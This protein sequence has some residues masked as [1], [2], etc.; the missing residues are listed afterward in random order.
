MNDRHNLDARILFGA[1]FYDEYRVTGSL[2]GDLDLMAAAGFS[3][4]RV[5]ESVWST[6]EPEPGRFNLDWLEPLLDA[7]ADRGI[8]V[9]LGTP[10]YAVPPWLQ[11]LHPEIA[12]EHRTGQP[13]PWGSRQEVNYRSTAFLHYAERVIRAVMGRY[14]QHP[15]IIGF[16]VDNEPGFHLLHNADVFEGFLDHL[17]EK[18]GTVD[19]LNAEW[20]LTYW[21]HLLR[22]WTDLW[23]PDG[24]HSPQYQVEWR[25]Y[26]AE[27]VADFIAW[28]SGIVRE[29][30]QDEQFVTTCIS[31]ER[32]AVDDTAIARSLDLPSGNPYYKMQDALR[33]GVDVPR[34][35]IWWSSGVWGLFEQGDRMFSTSQSPFLV[36]E[37]NAQSIGQS[38]WEIHPPY[39][40]QI[41]LAA[42]SLI[43]RGAR[44]IEYWQWQTL[45]YGIETYWGGVLPHSGRP[46]RIYREVADLGR[47]IRE[48]EPALEGYR[49]DA[50]VALL[51]STDT[52]RSFEFYPPLADEDGGPDAHAY[53]RI[54]DA[55]YR[56][57][58][59][60]GAQVRIVHVAQLLELS[61]E[62]AV[63]AH[64]V[65][66]VPTLYVATDA[67]LAALVEYARAGGHLVAGIRT[68]YGDELAR[69]R[70]EIAPGPLAAA[71]G[72]SYDE[73]SSLDHPVGI[74]GL[75]GS[76]EA[77]ATGW[78][79]ALELRGAEPIVSYTGGIY[80][81][82]PAVTSNL[83]GRGRVTYVGTVP[84]REL[85][86]RILRWAAPR[87][88][89]ST[90]NASEN[91][92]VVSGTST[93][94]RVWFVS[95][96]SSEPGTIVV[97]AEMEEDGTQIAAGSSVEIAP[98]H[99]RILVD[100]AR[101]QERPGTD[102]PPRVDRADPLTP[103]VA[104]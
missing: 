63:A 25:R 79:D 13:V 73:Y 30:A 104:S 59:E 21:S 39:P 50:D 80:E 76:L 44:M 70:A 84:G 43:S 60:S 24:N 7:A 10:T 41:A 38:Q 3:V 93:T 4:I 97:P 87:T 37:T 47:R 91:L 82:H 40:G 52:K 102:A 74:D 19:R 42:F 53:L 45:H 33:L 90:W 72:V 92:T 85:A 103:A 58:F 16:Q 22:D 77:Q 66:V 81:G 69:A 88:L 54:F 28:Q 55:F 56:G 62:E 83:F 67:E 23:A 11:K 12:A 15:S 98:W 89:S 46:G 95:N 78:A 1:A 6:W 94:G 29:Y 101:V 100:R 8:D 99:V 20:G 34:P 32:L 96:W 75:F 61:A 9:V 36:T 86:K 68:G 17:R 48:I 31:Y 26:Q 49:P 65:L 18:Y 14:A 57:A 51:Y 71:A 35:E 5:G 64:P 2:D 27:V